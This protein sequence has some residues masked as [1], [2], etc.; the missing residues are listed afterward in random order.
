MLL[1]FCFIFILLIIT[2]KDIFQKFLEFSILRMIWIREFC[3]MI[4]LQKDFIK[5]NRRNKKKQLENIL[6]KN[7][8]RL[9]YFDVIYI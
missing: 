2:F 8:N 4:V 3:S 5:I 9:K 7:A 6:W 1:I